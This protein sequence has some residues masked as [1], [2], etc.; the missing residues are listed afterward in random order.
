MRWLLRATASDVGRVTAEAAGE[1]VGALPAPRTTRVAGPPAPPPIA[2]T[3][4]DPLRSF[5][6]AVTPSTDGTA[7][8]ATTAPRTR[9]RTPSPRRGAA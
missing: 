7:S 5:S 2:A 4:A 6:R 8:A 3:A 1:E 9:A